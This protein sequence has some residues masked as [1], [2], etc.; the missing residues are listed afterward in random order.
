MDVNRALRKA[1]DTGKVLIGARETQRALKT[2]KV[3]MVILAANCRTNYREEFEK[4]QN[5][6]KYWYKGTNMELGSACG[7]P[8]PISTI[9]VMDSGES[10]IMELLEEQ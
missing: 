4:Y 9:A 3:K 10:N 5:V 1:I 6:P 8:F 2:N 7:K